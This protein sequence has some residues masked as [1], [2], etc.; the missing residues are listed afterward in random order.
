MILCYIH[1]IKRNGIWY[2]K[3]LPLIKIRKD[4]SP[5][6]PNNPPHAYVPTVMCRRFDEYGPR[7]VAAVYKQSQTSA[8]PVE[9]KLRTVE[10]RP[11]TVSYVQRELR[12][13]VSS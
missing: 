4:D 1:I 8:Q 13:V 7:S 6:R 3:D 12:T 9:L 11:V 5:F 10:V 2:N